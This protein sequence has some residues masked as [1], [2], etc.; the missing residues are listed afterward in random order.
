[1]NISRRNFLQSGGL[2]MSAL[3]L[4]M[5]APTVFQRKLLA[6]SGLANKK[7]IFIFQQGGN[8]GVNTVIPRGD[9]EYNTSTRPSLYLP[10]GETIASGN[11]FAEFHPALAPMMEI[12]NHSG[13]NGVDGAGNMAVLHRIGYEGQSRSHFDSQHYWQNGIPGDA[14]TEEGFIYRYVNRSVDLSVPENAFVAAGLSGSQLVALKGE[15][16][17]P[18]FSRANRFD[19]PAGAKFL[20]EGPAVPGARGGSGLLGLYGGPPDKEGKLYRNLVH[21]SG[22]TLGAALTTVQEALGQGTYRPENGADYPNN[23][24]G[25]KLREAA[26]LMKRTDVRIIGMRIGGWDTHEGQGQVNGKHANLLGTV[27]QGF[28]AIHRDLQSQWDDLIV[29]TMTEFGRTSKENGSRGTDH[30]E[31]SVMFVAGGGV[32]GGVYNCDETTWQDG[33]LFSE[34][35]RY[36]ERRTDFRAVFSEIFQKHFGD[37][38][39]SME[40]IIPGYTFAKLDN[41]SDFRPLNFL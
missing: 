28:Q 38:P 12:Y 31:S 35:D 2:A 33:D 3:G 32:K 23:S 13:I 20:G 11:G 29:V 36:V 1:M 21:G 37:D 19:L 16:T 41:P 7:M 14:E 10:S 15:N 30:A 18:N 39:G 9:S 34:R 8:D 25:D 6:A 27:A 4:N 17:I 5:L 22:Q 24:L 26:M 40:D